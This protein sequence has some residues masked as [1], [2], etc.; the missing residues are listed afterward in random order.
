[1][2]SGR[3]KKSFL[4]ETNISVKTYTFL[5]QLFLHYANMSFVS[6]SIQRFEFCCLP[7]NWAGLDFEGKAK[8]FYILLQ[9]G[10][11]LEKRELQ[12]LVD[13]MSLKEKI[14]Q[15]TQ[16]TPQYLG[17][18]DGELTGIMGDFAVDQVYL[19]S[20]GSVLNATDRNEVIAMQR[21]HL[22]KDRLKI[23]LVFM[24]DI[25][26]GYRTTF[27]IPLGLGATFAPQLVEEVSH[28][29]GTES[30]REGIQVTFS[31]M[32]DL[33]RD[34]RWGRV[35][36][37]TGEDPV[38]NAQMAAAMVRGYQ[39]APGELVKDPTRIAACVKHYAGYGAVLAGRDYNNVDFSRLSLYQDYLPAFQ[40]AIEAGAKLIMPAFTLFEGLPATASEY[41]LKKVLRE[42]L[43]FDG[44]AISD[45]GSVGKLLTMHIADSQERASELALNAGLDMDMMAG[46]F[47][48]GLSDAVAAKKVAVE[49]VDRA[50]LRMLNLKNDLGLFENPYRFIDAHET[51]P[52]APSSESRR[53]ARVAAEKSV[54]LLKN[55][56]VLPISVKSHIAVTGPL[57]AS[58]RILGAWSSYGKHDDAVS[59]YAGLKKQFENV[60]LI[61]DPI[62]SDPADYANFDVIIVG[63][64]E[65]EDD[66]GESA[67]K[68][69]IELPEDQVALIRRLQ[70]TG[71][72]IIGVIFAGRPLALTNV[73]PYLDGLLY[74]WFP[75]TEG[76]NALANL[77]SGKAV[78]EGH[79]PMTFPRTTGQVPI[80]YNEPRN[81]SPA[82][83]QHPT[84]F[85]SRYVDCQNSPLYPFGYGL[86][87]GH[88][89]YGK[90]QVNQP[91]LTDDQPIQ[92]T[93]AVTNDSD[94]RSSTL[95]QCY[96]GSTITSVVRPVSELK[97]W[98]KVVLEP[99]QTDQ[100]TLTIS[101]D[102]LAYVHSNLER[103]ADKGD[104]IVRIGENAEEYQEL[105]LT[106]Q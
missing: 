77:I 106:Y 80:Y 27:P 60:S 45:W 5:L 71:K 3:T 69:R 103:F 46:A 52:P 84:K 34:A 88:I 12:S 30:A 102:D 11:C 104:F 86:S 91:V 33:C 72:P 47:V 44:V 70:H 96:V 53:Y 19:D 15:L 97:S 65:R 56:N 26:H 74:A 93:V 68:T 55:K 29:A 54:V 105:T 81:G 83:D 62:S 76:G 99:N 2:W 25:I 100:V 36:E 78:P 41:L 31:P 73:V 1:M 9:G 43:K 75:G 16:F 85:T 57:A 17:R 95:V 90:L 23:P 20:L 28:V 48:R 40:A 4:R 79:L 63:L 13:K 10:D 8:R 64:G 98:V 61:P 92:I 59:L 24:R 82:D 32:A 42:Y 37:G 38:L 89:E 39:G 58:Q 35:M 7:I 51:L 49:D 101:V 6:V 66:S 14:G 22:K 18:E 21:E 50:V 87:Y 67:C 94:Y